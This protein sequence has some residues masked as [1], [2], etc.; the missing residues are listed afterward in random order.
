MGKRLTQEEFEKRVYDCVGDKFT[1]ISEY[2]GRNQKVDLHCNIHN[3][4]FSVTAECFMRGKDNIRGNCPKCSEEKNNINRIKVE[5]AYC[6]K[7]FYIPKSRLNKSKSGLYF[8]CRE[9]KDL[10]QRI[11]SG[12]RF[13]SMRPAHYGT[14]SEY[15]TLAFRSYPHEC[16]VC[17]WNEDER[18][19]E[20]HHID[21][22][23]KNNN[24]D[25]LCILCPTCHRKITLN[26][27]TLIED[28]LIE[29]K[30]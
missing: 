22:N 17:G 27:Y 30:D 1:V 26:Y 7:E 14:S 4:D 28:K 8:C 6:G 21:G 12:N 13:N 11:D 16:K 18:I 25:N 15:R 29:N 20:V 19:L 23:R 10:A 3:I 2:K 5:C 9:H 24:I